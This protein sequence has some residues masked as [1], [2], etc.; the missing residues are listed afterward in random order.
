MTAT[1]ETLLVLKQLVLLFRKPAVFE[2][3]LLC[4]GRPGPC[5]GPVTKQLSRDIFLLFAIRDVEEGFLV[6]YYGVQR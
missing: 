6:G 2:E 3:S 4:P 5:G 1:F